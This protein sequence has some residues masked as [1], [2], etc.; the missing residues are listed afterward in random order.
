MQPSR[1]D[2]AEVT[3]VMVE[4]AEPA[5]LAV[6]TAVVAEAVDTIVA[7]VPV[8]PTAQ[9]VVAAASIVGAEGAPSSPAKRIRKPKVLWSP[10]TELTAAWAGPGVGV[11]VVCI[12][13]RLQNTPHETTMRP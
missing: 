4:P 7:G 12:V 2:E 10:N 9:Q 1:R 3:D 5:E 8:Q 6:A 11:G 13:E